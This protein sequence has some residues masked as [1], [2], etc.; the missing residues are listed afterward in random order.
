MIRFITAVAAA[1]LV[2]AGCGGGGSASSGGSGGKPVRGGILL[3]AINDNPD[4]LD[5]ALSYTNEGWETL[6]ATNN[7]LLTFKKAAGGAGNEIVPDIA[8]AMPKISA[9]GTTYTFQ[10]R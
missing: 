8:K 3:A 5:P 1:A 6:E 10:L 2:A 9:D 4:H 7:G